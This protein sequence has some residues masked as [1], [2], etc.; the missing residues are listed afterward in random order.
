MIELDLHGKRILVVGAS[1]GI[2]RG[3]ALSAGKAG[4]SLAVVG[5]RAQLL[6]D[7]IAAAGGGTAIVADV[8]Q[9][10]DC[11]RV[12]AEALTALGG[13][14]AVVH[15][16]G[17]EWPQL[18]VDA[19]AA[20][21]NDT[22]AV[23]VTGPALITSRALPH[24]AG[25]GIVAFMSSSSVG[26]PY[27]GLT[28]YGASKAAVDEMVKGFALEHPEHRFTCLAIGPTLGT[29]MARGF[30]E[31]TMP[32]FSQ[33]LSHGRLTEQL[34][35]AEDLGRAVTEV[36]AML[37]AHPGVNMPES[38]FMPPGGIQTAGESVQEIVDTVSEVARN[39][40]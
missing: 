39:A 22:F 37:L 38:L 23:N 11:D 3:I 16:V 19:D 33:W 27:H 30:D 15:A 34:M 7:V 4:A 36:V 18:L 25:D 1:S 32:L 14:D 13:F 8:S 28:A 17:A 24:V 9:P 5:R 40:G 26:V 21:W 29:D 20:N 10:D 6:D 31:A 2:G 12:V 35:D